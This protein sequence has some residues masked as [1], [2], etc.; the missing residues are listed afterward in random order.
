MNGG[1]VHA[2][3]A[4]W[5]QAVF[6]QLF[7]R[8]RLAIFGAA[9]PMPCPQGERMI[10]PP[11][12]TANHG[13]CAQVEKGILGNMLYSLYFKGAI[14]PTVVPGIALVLLDAATCFVC[15]CLIFVLGDVGVGARHCTHRF[16]Q[17]YVAASSGGRRVR[18]R[19]LFQASRAW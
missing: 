14:A 12:V 4:P 18:G 3:A 15:K 7:W 1:S 6:Y 13:R 17:G 10:M 2:S 11:S 19:L 8:G 9:M 5:Y 16:V